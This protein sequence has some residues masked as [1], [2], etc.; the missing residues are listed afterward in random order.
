MEGE[1]LCVCDRK[2]TVGS[3]MQD[4]GVLCVTLFLNVE[5]MTEDLSA[6]L[7]PSLASLV[8]MSTSIPPRIQFLE[9]DI[10]FRVERES[11]RVV[12]RSCK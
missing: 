1:G 4:L 7:P 6:N 9:M 10:D 5:A 2:C 12:E 3:L 8:L 11:G